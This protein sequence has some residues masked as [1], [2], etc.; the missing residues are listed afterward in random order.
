MLNCLGLNG[1]RQIQTAVFKIKYFYSSFD[2]LVLLYFFYWI[3]A[4]DILTAIH[5]LQ[6]HV[7]THCKKYL[8]LILSIGIIILHV[9]HL[10]LKAFLWPAYPQNFQSRAFLHVLSLLELG[11]DILSI[12]SSWV[13]ANSQGLGN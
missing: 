9:R 11:L 7:Q 10:R 5:L 3:F 8:P 4:K 12:C 1:I 6:I 2:K 13:T